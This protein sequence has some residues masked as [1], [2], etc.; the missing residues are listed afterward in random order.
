MCLLAIIGITEQI[1][2]LIIFRLEHTLFIL[3]EIDFFIKVSRIY[4][5]RNT[6]FVYAYKF[7][8]RVMILEGIE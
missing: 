2:Y 3:T 8:M 7:I 6:T 4:Y 5:K 1:K